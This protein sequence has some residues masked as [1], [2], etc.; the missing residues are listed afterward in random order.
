MVI[1]SFW[2]PGLAELEEGSWGRLFPPIWHCCTGRNH[3][4]VDFILRLFWVRGLE[5]RKGQ[6]LPLPKGFS[7]LRLAQAPWEDFP[8]QLHSQCHRGLQTADIEKIITIRKREY[9]KGTFLLL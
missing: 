7:V 8:G 3:K 9:G 4:P 2:L 1:L 5:G 6:F